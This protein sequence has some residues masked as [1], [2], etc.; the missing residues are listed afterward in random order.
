MADHGLCAIMRLRH[1]GGTLGD[2]REVAP[3]QHHDGDV[4]G[5]DCFHC[6]VTK[7]QVKTLSS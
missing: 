4:G 2:N 5:A 1:H 3:R 6:S 7:M